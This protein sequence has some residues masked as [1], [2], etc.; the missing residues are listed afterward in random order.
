MRTASF[1]EDSLY[2][3]YSLVL[4]LGIVTA[5]MDTLQGTNISPQNGI[6]K[7][8]FLFPRWDM[9]PFPG[10]YSFSASRWNISNAMQ[11]RLKA[12][13]LLSFS[14]PSTW[15][16]CSCRLNLG[17]PHQKKP[18]LGTRNLGKSRKHPGKT[19]ENREKSWNLKCFNLKQFMAPGKWMEMG[20]EDDNNT[21]N[22]I[23]FSNERGCSCVYYVCYIVK[24]CVS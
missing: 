13:S 9:Y 4:L 18:W 8:I 16:R 1:R 21:E 15:P 17:N 22:M 3:E 10:V 2:R 14:A 6:L 24:Y 7:M 19:R 11:R 5:Q 12:R 20:E 23:P